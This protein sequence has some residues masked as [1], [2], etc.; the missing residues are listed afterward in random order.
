VVVPENLLGKVTIELI[1]AGIKSI[2][3]EKPGG[4]SIAEIKKVAEEAKKNKTQVFVGY[5]RRQYAAVA[6]AQEIIK[7]DGGVNSF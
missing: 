2:L 4:G 7:K 1:R 6:K 3:V 5:N